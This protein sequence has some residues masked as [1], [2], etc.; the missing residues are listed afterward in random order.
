MNM[1]KHSEL[2]SDSLGLLYPWIILLGIYVMLNGHQSP[3]GGFQ[4]G[5][6]LSAVFIEKYLILPVQEFELDRI[7]R[8]EKLAL[9]LILIFPITFLFIGL[10]AYFP[11]FNPYYVMILNCLIGLKVTCGFSLIF[12]RFV[13]FEVR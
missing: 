1:N 2:L 6:I 8:V 13:F 9:L 3:G 10:N 11:I 12:F 5:A 4:G 7:Q